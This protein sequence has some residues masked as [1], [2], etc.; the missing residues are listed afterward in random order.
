MRARGSRVRVWR[1]GGSRSVSSRRACSMGGGEEALDRTCSCRD[2][3]A[4]GATRDHGR[5]EAWPTQ[6]TP[7]RTRHRRSRQQQ[8]GGR[9]RRLVDVLARGGGGHRGGGGN[10]KKNEDK[11]QGGDDS[12]RSECSQSGGAA[13]PLRC[14]IDHRHEL[15]A[16]WCDGRWAEWGGKLEQGNQKPSTP[17]GPAT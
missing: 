13:Q 15:V 5:F 2:C 1:R 8:T 7:R 12:G 6:T 3:G 9:P 11:I 16:R 14:R 4:G 10:A 17:T